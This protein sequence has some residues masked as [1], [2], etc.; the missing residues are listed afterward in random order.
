MTEYLLGKIKDFP[1]RKGRAFRAGGKTIAVFRTN[2]NFYALAN[3]CIHKGASLCDGEISENGAVVRCPWH[4]WGFDLAS[5]AHWLDP[6]E[7]VRT[8][9]VR[10]DGD[11]VILKL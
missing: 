7:R 3:R 10:L 6:K 5:G 4:N 11:Q 8:Y 2:G 9:P 1:D